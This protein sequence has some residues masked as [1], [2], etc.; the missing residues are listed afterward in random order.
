[1]LH[2]CKTMLDQHRTQIDRK[3]SVSAVRTAPSVALSPLY[4]I[5]ESPRLIGVNTKYLARFLIT[6]LIKRRDV[7]HENHFTLYAFDRAIFSW[8]AR[9]ICFYSASCRFA[10]FACSTRRAQMAWNMARSRNCCND[11]ISDTRISN[12]NPSVLRSSRSLRASFGTLICVWRARH[13][14]NDQFR[15]AK[16]QARPRCNATRKLHGLSQN[17]CYKMHTRDHRAC[18]STWCTQS[19]CVL[20]V[21]ITSNYQLHIL[22]AFTCVECEEN[23]LLILLLLQCHNTNQFDALLQLKICN[24]AFLPNGNSTKIA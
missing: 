16:I 13:K 15:M 2:I 14:I 22:I 7:K 18:I 3:I 11:D 6:S 17:I 5:R 21:D 10:F 12:G 1:M 8:S 4:L 23:I 19:I 9:N 24:R 20:V